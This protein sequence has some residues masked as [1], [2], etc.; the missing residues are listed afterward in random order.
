MPQSK[1]KGAVTEPRKKPTFD[2]DGSLPFYSLFLFVAIATGTATFRTGIAYV[3]FTQGTIV[4][5]AVV[6]TVGYAATDCG[7]YFVGFTIHS[8]NPPFY[9]S[10]WLIFKKILTFLKIYCTIEKKGE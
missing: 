9:K 5:L 3:D 8:K 4:T 10:V 1:E 2:K 7:I 6:L